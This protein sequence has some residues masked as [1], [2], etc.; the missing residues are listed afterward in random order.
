[1]LHT[2]PE[3]FYETLSHLT[4]LRA[5]LRDH[6]ATSETALTLQDLIDFVGMYEAAD[7]R[8]QSTSP[9]N[10]KA[11]AVQLMTVFKAK[12]LEF[13]HVFLPSSQDEVWGS[14]S[15]SQSNRLTLPANLTPIRHAGATDDERLRILYV[16]ITRAKLGLHITSVAQNYNGKATKHLK[17]LDEREQDDGSVKSMALPERAQTVRHDDT[18]P[19][20][21]ELLELDWRRRHTAAVH[22][23]S[24]S[25]L[26]E[27][28]LKQYQLSPTHLNTFLDLE[29]GGPERFFFTTILRFPEAPTLDGQFGNAIH[30]TLEWVQ[31]AVTERGS[32]PAIGEAIAYFTARM[33]AKKLVPSRIILEIEHGEKALAAYLTA[34]STIFKPTDKAEFTFKNE[35]VFIGKAHLA[36]KIDRL[37]IDTKNKTITV[38]DYKTGKS[39][40]RWESDAKLHRYRRQLYSY[41]LL[42]EKSTTFAGYTVTHGR[43]E[44]VEPDKNNRIN[45]L[46]IAFKNDELQHT[47]QLLV[48]MW[49]HVI[50]LNFP[51]VSNYDATLAGIRQFEQDLLASNI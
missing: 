30:E 49:Q 48:A 27:S 5:R 38:V 40:S 28:R 46:E 8:M 3:L 4:V 24:L 51:D 13:E 7:E 16:A 47:K 41:K 9:Y 29:Y 44:F 25:N 37:E 34:R 14:S 19:P 12:G 1:M 21:I 15:R 17:Y 26:L 23:S 6:Q 31:H 39:Y 43:L 45:S 33:N 42:V 11:D 32:T 2:Q 22:Q 50:R 10:Q 35:G 18:A 20:A 36:G